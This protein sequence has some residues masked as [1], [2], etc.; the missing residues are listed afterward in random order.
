MK[1]QK[2]GYRLGNSDASS[3]NLKTGLLTI[4]FIAHCYCHFL[5]R[6]Q[7]IS[8]VNT[9]TY[10]LPTSSVSYSHFSHTL[11]YLQTRPLSFTCGADCTLHRGTDLI[12]S[13]CWHDALVT[14]AV[15]SAFQFL[16]ASSRMLLCNLMF[17]MRWRSGYKDWSQQPLCCQHARER[18]CTRWL[19]NPPVSCWS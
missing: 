12:R 8:M 15:L 16:K 3:L 2:V 7:S 1:S 13:W 4:T 14:L 10:I 18:P 9:C 19:H 17:T 5:H 11:V 6:Y